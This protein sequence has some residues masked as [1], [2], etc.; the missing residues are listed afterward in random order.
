MAGRAG[1]TCL[2]FIAFF[3][4]AF[5]GTKPIRHAVPSS[6][7]D[8]V[9]CQ[10][11]LFPLLPPGSSETGGRVKNSAWNEASDLILSLVIVPP[12]HVGLHCL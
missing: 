8:S 10:K 11:T 3:E 1:I 2:P 5:L 7:F 9:I 12:S 6:S 4:L